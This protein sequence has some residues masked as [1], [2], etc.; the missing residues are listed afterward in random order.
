MALLIF[1]LTLSILVL[2]HE[3]GHYIV[4][5]KN[6]IRVEEFGL[7]LPPRLFGKKFGE[8]LYSIN[9]LPFGGFV[10]LT[11]ED[12]ED[13]SE[14]ARSDPRN[15][16]SKTPMQRAAVLIA[17]VTMNMILGVLCF[18]LFLVLNSF[19][20]FDFP[21]FFEYEFRFGNTHATRTVITQLKEDGPAEQAGIQLGEAIISIDGVS[22]ST[23]E[24]VKNNLKGKL[25]QDVIVGLK[26]M[27]VRGDDN[28]RTITTR[29]VVIEG[30][31][32]VI[33]IYM[34]EFIAVSYD[35]PHQKL[36]SGFLHSYNMTAYSLK[37]LGKIITMSVQTQDI[38]PVSQSIAGPVGIYQLVDAIL[39]LELDS[40][41][42]SIIDYVALMSLSLAI[43]NMMPLPALDG[44]RVVF[45]LI[46][47]VRGKPIKQEIEAKVHRFGMIVLLLLLFVITLKDIFL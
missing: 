14:T 24:E 46:E 40:A 31:S 37:S 23:F 47:A 43:F 28:I 1:I 5:K 42:L 9:L 27:T 25:E 45:V 19:R 10:K 4:A 20:S 8:T 6:G 15:F 13:V 39:D 22:V 44:G 12:M 35:K 34:S 26:D 36:L 21:L 38:T 2:V 7:G 3:F 17:G 30:G 33:G 41:I 29:P 32:E 11:G 18:Y 16:L